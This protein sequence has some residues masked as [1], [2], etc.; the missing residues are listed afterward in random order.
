MIWKKRQ[1]TIKVG[2]TRIRSF[3]AW[4]PYSGFFNGEWE[5][6][7]LCRVFVEE[8]AIRVSIESGPIF[9]FCRYMEA[10]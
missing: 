9:V 6:H 10:K 4:F 2:D 7:W 1:P 8:V 3:F 5:T